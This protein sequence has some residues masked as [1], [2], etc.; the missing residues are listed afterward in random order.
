MG[1]EAQREGRGW[2]TGRDFAGFKNRNRA[3][4]LQQGGQ[5]HMTRKNIWCRGKTSIASDSVCVWW[6]ERG[7]KNAL[8][9]KVMDCESSGVKFCK[10]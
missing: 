5:G 8:E 7:K 2:D 4:I 1:Q 10:N 9:L 6:K 3:T